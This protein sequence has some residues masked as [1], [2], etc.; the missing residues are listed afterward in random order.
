MRAGAPRGT[1][2]GILLVAGTLDGA[3]ERTSVATSIVEIAPDSGLMPVLWR[4]LAVLALLL[5]AWAAVLESRRYRA[6]GARAAS[7]TGPA[8]H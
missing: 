4:P 8:E 6:A 2:H 3:L 7:E 1:R 5:L